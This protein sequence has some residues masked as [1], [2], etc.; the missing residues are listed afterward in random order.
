LANVTCS[1]Q[2]SRRCV[3][4][5]GEKVAGPFFNGPNQF[6]VTFALDVTR[7][8]TGKRMTLE[9]VAVYTVKEERWALPRG[10]SGSGL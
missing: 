7:K 9:E 4:F 8:P 2:A 10:T 6:A 3:E 1:G 5:H